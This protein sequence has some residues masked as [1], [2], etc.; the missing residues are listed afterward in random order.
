[1]AQST[2]TIATRKL[3]DRASWQRAADSLAVLVAVSLPWSTSAT[4]ILVALWL[5]ALIPTLDVA[6]LRKALADPAGGLPVALWALALI[7][8]VWGSTG[9]ED[10]IYAFNGFHKLLAIPLLIVQFARS[11]KGGQVVLGFLVSCTVLLAASWMYTLLP[12]LP[13]HGRLVP[14]VPVK[15]YIVQSGEF[16]LCA[17]ALGHLA[18]SAWQERRPA[19]AV[20]L[21]VLALVF[22]GNVFYVAASRAMLVV[23]PFLLVSLGWQ[24]FG[25]RGGVGTLVA[26]ALLAAGAWAS[27]PYLRGRVLGVV[28]EIGLYEKQAAETSSGY[29]LEFWKKSVE[30]IATA[31]VIGH[32]TGSVEDQFRRLAATD[33]EIAAVVTHNPHN[34]TLSIAIQY[35]LIGVAVL[36]AMWLAHLLLFRGPSLAAWLGFAV[37]VQNVVASLFNSQLFYFVPGW[38]YVFGVGVLGGTLLAGK[39]IVAGWRRDAN[40]A[41]K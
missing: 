11:D 16:L 6:G 40:A 39:T 41:K 24:R 21:A 4:S 3:F 9:F 5:V 8:M 19:L 35:G 38:T 12:W 10:Q 36:Y 32:G 22:L 14:G 13:G 33:S 2:Q 23:L 20:V 30:I 25:W 17:Y 31:P 34:Q 7:G 15:E 18:I 27:S 37:V 28:H 1:M 26:G 29:R